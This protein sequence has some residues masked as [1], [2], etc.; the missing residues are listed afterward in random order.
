MYDMAFIDAAK[1][2]IIFFDKIYP[3]IKK[4]GEILVSD[5]IFFRGQVCQ[6][7]VLDVVKRNRTIYRR[8][9]DCYPFL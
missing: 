6:D 5:N 8:M 4:R 1:G 7:S 2:R 3:H 9:N